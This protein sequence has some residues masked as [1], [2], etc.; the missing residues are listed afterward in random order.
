MKNNLDIKC[1]RQLEELK[2]EIE[3][4][5]KTIKDGQQHSRDTRMWHTCVSH[6]NEY[7]VVIMKLESK[8][9]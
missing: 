7:V 4:S 5:L 6:E 3:M 1:G 2:E 8:K 9:K